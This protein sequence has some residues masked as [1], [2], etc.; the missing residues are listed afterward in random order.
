MFRWLFA[1]ALLTIGTTAYSLAVETK[2]ASPGA[3]EFFEKSIRP[4]LAEN[5]FSCHGAKKQ[6]AGLRLDSAAGLAKGI[7]AGPVVVPGK[8]EQ[9]KLIASV[10]RQGDNAM[11]PDGELTAEQVAAL[12]EWVK[13]GAVFPASAATTASE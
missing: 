2:P 9:S 13:Q 7:D 3:V 5:C 8:P 1:S 12:T 4:I 10:R 6:Q 11:P